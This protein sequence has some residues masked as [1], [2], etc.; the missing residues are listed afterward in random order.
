MAGSWWDEF[1]NNLATDLAP[2]I[3]LF[4]E[5]PTK[6]YL[7]ECL[8]KTD[9]IIFS[10]APLGIIT[11]IVS[12]IRVCGT[13]SLRAFIG[14]AQEGAGNAEAE[15]CSSTS[16]EVCELYNN[17]GIARVFGRPKLLEIVHDRNATIEDFYSDNPDLQAT[18]GIYFFKDYLK[19]DNQEW[20]EVG[21]PPS[22]EENESTQD[23]PSFAINPNLSL[24]VGIKQG[25]KHWFTAAAI[26][27]GLLQSSV[28]VWA[29][30]ARYKFNDVRRDLQDTY[31]IPLAV[32]GTCLLCLGTGLCAALIE[33]S[34]K[35]RIFE[36]SPKED[37]VSASR[38]YWVQPGTQFVGDQAFDSF[39][40]THP[41]GDFTRYITSWKTGKCKYNGIGVW[42]AISCTSLGFLLQ[43]LGLRACHSSV[44]VAQ[45]GATLVMSIVRSVLRANRLSDEE[46]YLVDSPD[47]YKGHELDWLA[48]ELIAGPQSG[49]RA[50]GAGKFGPKWT[51]SPSQHAAVHISE[52]R[53]KLFNPAP[54]EKGIYS[55]EYIYF[56]RISVH[57]GDNC[58]LSGFRL[59]D[60]KP[61]KSQ[62]KQIQCQV[63]EDWWD[64]C[65]AIPEK[66]SA[67][68]RS[69]PDR[70]RVV[71]QSNSSLDKA[72]DNLARAFMYRT[73][74]HCMTSNWDEKLVPVRAIAQRLA[75]AVESTMHLFD[76]IDITWEKG[77]DSAFTLFWAVPCN[78]DEEDRSAG[79][80]GNIYISLKRDIGEDGRGMSRWCADIAELE[81]VLG[82]WLWSLRHLNIRPGEY[83]T[84]I[85][86]MKP[87]HSA[88][89]N[90]ISTFNLWSNGGNFKIE[91]TEVDLSRCTHPL[92]GRHNVPSAP[93]SKQSIVLSTTSH[94]T[95]LPAICA[96]E[97]YS[98]FFASMVH[99][100]Q[101]IG[102][103]TEVYNSGDLTLVNSNLSRIQDAFMRSG[104]GSDRDFLICTLPALI[105]KGNLPSI[106]EV[107][108]T[109]EKTAETYI[110]DGLWLK[111]EKLLSWALWHTQQLKDTS[112]HD[113][114]RIKEAEYLNRLR[115]LT[116]SLCECY[117]KALLKGEVEFCLKGITE[118]FNTLHE[119]ENVPLNVIDS[120]RLEGMAKFKD[121]SKGKVNQELT[122]K[123]NLQT[124]VDAV[125]S[126]GIA[127]NEIIYSKFREMVPT[128][129]AELTI[130]Q[131]RLDTKRNPLLRIDTNLP[132]R[133][134]IS[135]IERK[136]TLLLKAVADGS[137]ASTLSLLDEESAVCDGANGGQ[138]LSWATKQG[139]ISV[140]KALVEYGAALQWRDKDGRSTISFAAEMGDINSYD[141]LL[142]QGAFPG[143]ADN[144]SRTPVFYA[145]SQGHIAILNSL[146]FAGR[147]EPDLR[148]EDGKTP[149][150]MAAKNG[151]IEAVRLLLSTK[152]VK[153]D[154]L[155]N[156]SRT[157]LSYAAGN[158]HDDVVKLLLTSNECKPDLQ[159]NIGKSALNWAASNGHVNVVK[160]LLSCK[161]VEPDLKDANR[162]TPLFNAAFSN[163]HQVVETLGNEEAVDVNSE[164]ASGDVPL[165]VAAKGGPKTV[166][167]LMKTGRVKV[168]FKGDD[169]L[170]V[171]L[172]AI[173]RKDI[174]A[175]ET[176]VGIEGVDLKAHTPDGKSALL[177]SIQR[178]CPRIFELLA[179]TQRVDCHSIE[180][181]D[182]TPLCCA[183]AAQSF[184][185]VDL[186]VNKYGADINLG[187]DSGPPLVQAAEH[188]HLEIMKLLLSRKE[189]D[190]NGKDGLGATALFVAAGGIG[191]YPDALKAVKLLLEHGADVNL[192]ILEV[193]WSIL[194]VAAIK[195]SRE[196]FLMLLEV[197]K[198]ELNLKTPE[199]K[200]PLDF[201]HQHENYELAVDFSSRG[202][203]RGCEMPDPVATRDEEKE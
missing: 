55:T 176:L 163:H 12:A 117:R 166:Q 10:M 27:G 154:N 187:G 4:G 140:V 135:V 52:V 36:R 92:F 68:L 203:K 186:L 91:E 151:H 79:T 127:V 130:L 104:L 73:R 143:V 201:A 185:I 62:A 77:W 120:P 118:M 72:P 45:L 51:V 167:A 7:S 155:D 80:K 17:G 159:D 122:V 196:L 48:L 88:G 19:K 98:L 101:S 149:L 164:D 20:R 168:N 44:A 197:E 110:K 109:T 58:I 5:A 157:P 115:L 169:G 128:L 178:R 49:N 70:W 142:A 85:L 35:E 125:N 9:I 182:L 22:D 89:E 108:S 78:L 97:I 28:L 1:S 33:G 202:C 141:Y 137:L 170:T 75:D 177:L 13:P 114:S 54:D 131:S 152:R 64:P 119:Q 15:L 191:A 18:A 147:V 30:I 148:D 156:T 84:R 106:L 71:A 50:D 100:T 3:S 26:F 161:E 183:A 145:T 150:S 123:G 195:G 37:R 74:L 160:T 194:H 47:L 132:T 180:N 66:W 82:L 134:I 199:G 81:A 111:A 31:A 38:L 2:L 193:G 105:A 24:N 188:C 95:S 99:I 146:L 192:Q 69:A 29:T 67:Y 112:D 87:Q 53:W 57:Q 171:L 94:M 144:F 76:T 25:S 16:R 11:T 175:V 56:I 116:L 172:R 60:C 198:L 43:F 61:E 133:H 83:F 129:A 200:T 93:H 46:V 6:Q 41:E 190:V 121:D 181:S 113:G 139:W 86:A 184:G 63:P 189:I 96:Q 90:L 23:D 39:A 65:V 158:G 174:Q 124:L 107:L 40:Y 14:R 138:T 165:Y 179:D 126:Y 34:T 173:S 42:I 8:T 21:K 59:E 102:G 136:G 162:R 32:I 153:V 103:R